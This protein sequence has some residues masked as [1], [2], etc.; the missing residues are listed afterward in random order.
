[1][2][3]KQEIE[4][5]EKEEGVCVLYVMEGFLK[6]EK[7]S[8]ILVPLSIHLRDAALLYSTFVNRPSASLQVE[9]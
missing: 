2:K 7:H 4:R 6:A 3:K 5:E 8:S 9:D 1:V